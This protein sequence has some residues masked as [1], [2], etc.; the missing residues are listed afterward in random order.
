MKSGIDSRVIED[1]S[2]KTF[3]VT[4][5]SEA[6]GMKKTMKTVATS[7]SAKAIGMPVNITARVLAP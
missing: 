6:T 1:I 5:S 4:V 2:S 3:C 7:P